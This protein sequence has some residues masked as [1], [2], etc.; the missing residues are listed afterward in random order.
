MLPG[1]GVT[2]G[3]TWGLPH[4]VGPEQNGWHFADQALTNNDQQ[5]LS[6][7]LSQWRPSSLTASTVLQLFVR[8]WW[9]LC[10]IWPSLW[11]CSII[12]P[13][14][15]KWWPLWK[16]HM[17][18]HYSKSP[19]VK[20]VASTRFAEGL[21]KLG[22]KTP[23]GPDHVWASCTYVKPML[24]VVTQL[25]HW[26]RVTH[27][28]VSKLTIIVS[29][30]GLSPGRRQ[31]IIWNNAGLLLIEPLGTNFSEISIGIQRFLFKNMHLNMSS[32]NWRPFCLGLNELKM[33]MERCGGLLPL[34]YSF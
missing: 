10:A 21:A 18:K 6:L 11:P 5:A 32:A 25:S 13:I 12:N 26:G 31:A 34:V 20:T 1:W 27:I 9:P 7:Y 16:W 3:L 17:M 29:D 19:S 28:C 24:E 23:A 33:L 2:R 4:R 22:A 8:S 15:F 30:N 14:S